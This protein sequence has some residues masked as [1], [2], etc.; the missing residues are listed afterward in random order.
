MDTVV[1]IITA[2]ISS[3]TVLS[4]IWYREYLQ[5]RSK[6]NSAV[7]AQDKSLFYLEIDKICGTI[8]N[9]VSADAVYI[10]YFHN[11]GIFSNGVTMD[12]FTVVGEDYSDKSCI[13]SYKKQYSG[14]MINYMPYSYHRLLI[15]NKYSFNVKFETTDISFK[16]DLIRR[17]MSCVYMF[18]IKDPVSDKPLGFF[19]IEFSKENDHPIN[20]SIVWKY[21]NKLARLLNMTVMD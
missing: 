12:K 5:K 13:L 19:A 8:R 10:A 1:T 15:D 16:K 17:K 6:E 11:G 3:I 20:E 14:M 21:Q 4:S 9:N 18:L 2:I 7:S